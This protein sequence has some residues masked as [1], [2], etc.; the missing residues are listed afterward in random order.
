MP[1]ID[2]TADYQVTCTDCIYTRYYPY[3]L[4]GHAAQKHANYKGHRV[5]L[6][7][8]KGDIIETFTK[9]TPEITP[10]QPPY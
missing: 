7:D 4:A 6:L 5:H 1:D 10:D 8:V 2:K 9:M 3:T